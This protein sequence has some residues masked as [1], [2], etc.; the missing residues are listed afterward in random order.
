L[1]R[2]A[3][4]GS[5]AGVS[6]DKSQFTRLSATE[7]VQTA[8]RLAKR[9][10]ARFPNAGLA[11]VAA[12]LAAVARRS[13]AD[14]GR[15]AEPNRLIRI[16]VAAVLLAGVVVAAYVATS[17]RLGHVDNDASSVVQAIEATVNVVVLVGIGVLALT[18]MEARWKRRRALTSLHRLRSLAHVIDMHQ[19][20]KDFATTDR[21]VVAEGAEPAL[22]PAELERYL[23]YCT[24]LLSIVGKL[25]ALYAQ[26]CQDKGINEAVSDIEVL[27]T[28]L[29][30]KI[31]QKIALVRPLPLAGDNGVAQIE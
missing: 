18:Q 5:F 1:A 7:I 29:S 28:N 16:S 25:A 31:W 21:S 24:E 12:E 10:K 30:R 3:P 20:A 19:L 9:I 14:A 15:L 11:E 4:S 23:D 8:E 13:G 2:R 27:T 6:G 17:I 26:S 22:S